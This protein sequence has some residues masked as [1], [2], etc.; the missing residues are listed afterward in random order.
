[1][2]NPGT[3]RRDFLAATVLGGALSTAGTGKAAQQTVADPLGRASKYKLRPRTRERIQAGHEAILAE[4]KP[5]KAQLERGLELHYESF[6]ADTQ[7]GISVTYPGGL[8]GDRLAA[9]KGLDRQKAVTFPGG[10]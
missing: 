6:V 8:I 9:D 5:T 10:I 3:T 1:M 7:G 2:L 4:L